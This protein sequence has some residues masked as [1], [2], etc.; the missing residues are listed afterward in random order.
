[1]LMLYL[2]V[3]WPITVR[4]SN[5]VAMDANRAYASEKTLS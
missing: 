1:M 4:I 3:S 2:L 5:P